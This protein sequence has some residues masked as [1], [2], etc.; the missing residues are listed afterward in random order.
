MK[1]LLLLPL[2]FAVWLPP[3]WPAEPAAL[4]RADE[5]KD[6][7][8]PHLPT[9]PTPNC[10]CGCTVTGKCSCKDCDHPCLDKDAKPA[11]KPKSPAP[12]TSPSVTMPNALATPANR[13]ARLVISYEGDDFAYQCSGGLDVFRE[14]TPDA[15]TVVLRLIGYDAGVYEVTAVSC[16]AGK[17][18]PFAKCT[19]TVGT[20]APPTP[21]VPPGPVS[22]LT[23][24]LQT[25]Y[26]LD[27]DIDKAA[28]LD[29]LRKL[30]GGMSVLVTAGQTGS[31]ISTVAGATAWGKGVIEST[32]AG[33]GAS[34]LVNTRKAVGARL[35]QTFGTVGTAPTDRAKFAAE[36][37]AISDA[38]GGVK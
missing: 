7:P 23:R 32:S 6:A 14:Y 11:D 5:K 20:P 29:T 8:K 16:K 34:K 21:P 13:L 22:D 37:K 15:S 31:D 30:Y 36:L 3:A 28:S 10:Q 12:A 9:P 18:S 33:L 26:N 27:L 4:A 19:V 2:L 17:L 24:A 1:K 35:A 38:L 25:G